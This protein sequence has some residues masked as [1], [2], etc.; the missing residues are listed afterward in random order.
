M[1]HIQRHHL[2]EAKVLVPPPELLEAM[3][4][5]LQPIIESMPGRL[6]LNRTLTSI[7]DALLSKLISGE[8]RVPEV[9]RILRA[10]P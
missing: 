9:E 2:S 10:M 7:R 8:L 5:I 6:V 1:G 4:Q 3:G